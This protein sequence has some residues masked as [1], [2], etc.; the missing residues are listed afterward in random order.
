MFHRDE[1]TPAVFTVHRSASTPPGMSVN[2]LRMDALK[3]SDRRE[4]DYET[5]LANRALP[6]ERALVVFAALPSGTALD[7][8]HELDLRRPTPP[9][10]EIIASFRHRFP[11]HRLLF[12]VQVYE[13]VDAS[14]V[15]EVTG[16]L[17]SA[18]L[19]V[20]SINGT[21][22]N[23]GLLIGSRSWAAQSG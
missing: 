8:R 16:L 17:D 14:S 22:R 18:E 13:R 20:Y 11:T 6:P 3:D 21:G 5:L 19:C 23:H 4:G 7:E 2:L 15:A 9:V 1:M 10:T 12:G